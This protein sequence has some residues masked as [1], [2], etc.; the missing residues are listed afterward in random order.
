MRRPMRRPLNRR[1]SVP[2]LI[3]GCALVGIL[4]TPAF[5]RAPRQEYSLARVGP[6]HE[7]TIDR[8]RP[9]QVFTPA[10]SGARQVLTPAR[11]RWHDLAPVEAR[12]S[13]YVTLAWSRVRF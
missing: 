9:R 3:A 12:A 2:A 13:V 4:A 7:Y 10:R 11:R 1:A 8:A 6:R 5:A